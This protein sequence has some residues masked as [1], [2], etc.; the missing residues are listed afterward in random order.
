MDT[1]YNRNR[2]LLNKILF[3]AGFFIFIYLLITYLL[4]FFAPF[5]IA[6]IIALV[7]EP[8][9]TFLEKRTRMPRKIA[10]IISLI[11]TLSVLGVALT[12]GIIKI[13]NE[14]LVLQNNISNYIDTVSVQ[15]TVYINKITAY[16]HNL[17]PDVITTIDAN[18]KSLAPKLE[19]IITSIAKYLISTITSIPKMTV[20]LIVTL[21]STYFISS[22][23]REI[24]SFVYKQLPETWTRNFPGIKS[25]TFT[26]LFGYVKALF[27]LVGFTFAEVSTGL[28]ILHVDFALLLGLIVAISDIIP[29]LGTG[30]IMVPWI[31]W[32]F[33]VGDT[34]MALGLTI[35]YILGII[36]RQVM[37]P[38]IVGNQIGLHPLVTLIA[39][40]I[41]LEMFGVIGMVIGPVSI[42][43]LKNLQRSGVFKIWD[44]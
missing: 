28:L 22:D 12:F 33:I 4:S 20:F 19:G 38:K 24:R 39:M 10:S 25:D 40:Y 31:A 42:I 29:I 34:Q 32:N 18:I 13:Y 44:E 36:I 3:L 27:I 1:F 41:G 5:V 16:Y 21:L 23:R 6:I 2:G 17:P 26:A 37:E 11:V 35:I 43:I 7:N 8:V 9:I 15:I 14:L 30:L